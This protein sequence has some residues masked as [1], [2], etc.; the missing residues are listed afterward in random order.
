M[1]IVFAGPAGVAT[2]R[3]IAIKNALKFYADTGMKVNRAY[4]PSA[5]LAAA[6]DITGKKFKRGQ[7]MEAVAAI[8]AWLKENGTTGT[9]PQ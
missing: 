9:A 5:M 8:D 3:A 2:F 6:T 1:S 7:Y 4:T